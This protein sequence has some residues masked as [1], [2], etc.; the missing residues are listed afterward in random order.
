MIA[1]IAA[2]ASGQRLASHLADSLSDAELVSGRPSDVLAGAFERFDQIVLFLAAG[3]AVRLISPLLSDK[4]TDPGV[5]CVDDCGRYAIPLAGGHSASA[6]Q[7]ARTV[8]GALGG[9]PVVTTATDSHGLPAL[10]RLGADIGFKVDA[11]SDLAAVTRALLDGKRVEF[12]SDRRWPIEPL[13]ANVAATPRAECGPCLVVTDRAC[14][15]PQPYILYRPASLVVGI[16]ASTGVSSQE[17]QALTEEALAEAGLSPQSLACA[18]TL[19]T[20]LTEPGLVEA[21][22]SLGLQLRGFAASALDAV[23]VPNPSA[24][25]RAA[26]G[27]KSVAEAAA[28]CAAASPAPGELCVT[29]RKSQMATVAVARRN[30]RGKLWL[31][32]LG[33][34]TDDLLPPLAR[35]AL[36]ASSCVVGLTRY[37]ESVRHLLRPNTQV[38]SYAIGEEVERARRAVE[39]A[40]C[41]ESVAIVS[42]GDVGIYGM[43]A[44]TLD[45]QSLSQVDVCVIPGISAAN[46]ASAVVGSPLGHDH[47]AISLSDRLTDW[48]TI[49]RRVE[50]AAEADF[51]ISFY[52]PRSKQRSWQL[53]EALSIISRHR[54]ADTPVAVVSD[55]Y[56]PLQQIKLTRLTDVEVCDVSMT[57][58]V[59]VGN[60]QTRLAS[61]RMVTP[62]GYRQTDLA[63]KAAGL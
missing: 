55:A 30:P 58:T 42:S 14:S 16:G 4:R 39:R 47:C 33:P 12:Q 24:P 1:L 9:E 15:P 10:D 13:P 17:I 28:L 48:N 44:P 36:Q 56:R 20:K 18:A 59:I 38:E 21:A 23:E 34:G 22:E 54:P 8:A 46:A 45:N 2:T 35:T 43:A 31:I 63:A 3:A 37:V 61:G 7:L 19:D 41:G 11:T 27:T 49:A 51:V 53:P 26:V 60:S 29:K 5:V 52:N 50:A 40:V 32:S 57:T 6:N 62:R 25:V